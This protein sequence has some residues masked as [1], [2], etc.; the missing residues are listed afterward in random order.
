MLCIR[1]CTDVLKDN[2]LKVKRVGDRLG[3]DSSMN[4]PMVLQLL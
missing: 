3:L 2:S 1:N 4:N